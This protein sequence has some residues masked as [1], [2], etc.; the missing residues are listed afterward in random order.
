MSTKIYRVIACISIFVSLIAAGLP[1][2]NKFKNLKVLPKNISEDELFK[3][4][5][6]FKLSLGV[7]CNYCHAKE[8]GTDD[9]DFVTDKKPEKEIARKMMLMTT[10]I[11]KKYFDFN[12]KPST[13][14]AVSCVTCHRGLPRPEIDSIP[15]AGK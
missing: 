4:M 11:N 1:A 12:K 5:D 9:L 10:D 13:I 2:Q 8:A 14:Q 7:V 3:M 6:H 15:Q